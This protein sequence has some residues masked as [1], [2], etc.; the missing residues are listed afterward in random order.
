MPVIHIHHRDELSKEQKRKLSKELTDVFVNVLNKDAD[1]VEIF[2]HDVK[3]HNFA[4]GGLLLEDI[5]KRRKK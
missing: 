5:L 2:W 1:L 4:R 3:D